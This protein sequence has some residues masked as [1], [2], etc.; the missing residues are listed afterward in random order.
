MKSNWIQKYQMLERVYNLC[1]ARINDFPKASAAASIIKALGLSVAKLKNHVSQ[2]VSGAGAIQ[3]S[4]SSHED[5][6][7]ELKT[8]LDL[9][10]Q[11]ARALNLEQFYL[12]RQRTDAAYIA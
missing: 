7:K 4:V 6:R 11:T 9:I 12:P 8:R 2:Q 10:F 1:L 3:Q 5:A